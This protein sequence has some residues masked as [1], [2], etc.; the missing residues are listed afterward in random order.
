M[1]GSTRVTKKVGSKRNGTSLVRVESLDE[2][3]INY[4]TQPS[5]EGTVMAATPETTNS[6]VVANVKH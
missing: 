6:Y 4:V 1:C 2:V 3:S 5:S